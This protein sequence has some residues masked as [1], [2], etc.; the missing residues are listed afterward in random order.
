MAESM[1]K[2]ASPEE[3][4]RL[5]EGGSHKYL[6]VRTQEEYEAGHVKESVN[7]PV[8]SSIVGGQMI[9][10]ADFLAQVEAKIPDKGTPLVVACKGGKRSALAIEKMKAIGYKDL[11]NLTGGYSAWLVS[12]KSK[13]VQK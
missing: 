8:F 13:D 2:E 12:E 3:A 6:D 7:V 1:G 4:R 11:T 9:P 10:N 5:L